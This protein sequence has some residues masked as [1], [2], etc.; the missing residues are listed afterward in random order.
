LLSG[1]AG[2]HASVLHV[3]GIPCV[4]VIQGGDQSP[5]NIG[6]KTQ[7]IDKQLFVVS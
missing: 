7:L 1:V 2:L 6:M 5:C 4:D 3:P